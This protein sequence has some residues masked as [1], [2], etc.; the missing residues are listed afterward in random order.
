M[1]WAVRDG[2]TLFMP[3]WWALA[4][5]KERAVRRFWNR[6]RRN[7]FFLVGVQG[8]RK[9]RKSVFAT[10]MEV[11]QVVCVEQPVS[12]NVI[13][14]WGGR[15][16]NWYLQVRDANW[17]DC[18]KKV[19]ILWTF[20][21]IKWHMQHVLFLLLTPDPNLIKPTSRRS[22]NS[23]TQQAATLLF[24]QKKWIKKL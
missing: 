7:F 12:A 6:I 4:S 24:W 17:S 8:K 3:L 19:F 5:S 23:T 9:K 20:F 13:C 18:L 22:S 14:S 1:P 15:Y 16:F 2:D 11:L 21:F 10:G